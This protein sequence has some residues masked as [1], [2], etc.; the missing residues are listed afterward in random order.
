MEKFV[1]DAQRI[2]LAG[3]R[4]ARADTLFQKHPPEAWLPA[5]EHVR[6][7]IVVGAGKAAMAMA[8]VF[9]D[10]L[11]RPID[12]G[13]V[14]VPHG[15]A[16]TYPT[17]LPPPSRIEVVE[18]GHPVPDESGM[19]AAR[20]V[21]RLVAEATEEDLVVVLLS[22]GGSS[23]LPA[24]A[25]AISLEDA[26]ETFRLLLKSG[27]TIQEINTVRKHIS[28]IGGGRLALQA[29]PAEVRTFVIS[30][31]V[32]DDLSVIASGPTVPDPTTFADA[33]AV[34]SRY[35]LLPVLPSS[36]RTYI[37]EALHHPEWET[38]KPGH[39]TFRKVQNRI[40]G[41]NADA[42]EAARE[43][44]L[45]RGYDAQI[46]SRTLQGEARKVA[47]ALIK[48]TYHRAIPDEPICFL[49][50]GETTVTVRGK[51]RGGR[52]QELALAAAINLRGRSDPLIVLS[53]NTDGIDGP[54]DAAG[55]WATPDTYARAL[56]MHLNPEHFL[57]SND[58]YTFFSLMRML[59]KTGP[60]HTNVMDLVMTLGRIAPVA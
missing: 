30:D 19:H 55:A 4:G 28:L 58:S 29:A 31:V 43:E 41:S 21:L 38:P 49:W 56:R 6:R 32:G 60:T 36:V 3:I 22:G 11:D 48:E 12:E 45:R 23:L 15:Y 18:A 57:E 14:V 59:I 37:E 51:G 27:A 7:L 2:A 8:G 9:E 35:K 16:A 13:L 34:L 46:C 40:I 20:A 53:I 54:T 26:R 33:L 10:R 44:A 17:D 1:R 42:L 24:F 39:P 47:G 25:D 5:L 52:N 50:S